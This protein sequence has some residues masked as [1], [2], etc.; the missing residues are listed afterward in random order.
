MKKNSKVYVLILS[1]WLVLASAVIYPFITESTKAP[2]L[3]L[4]ILLGLNGAFILY[5]WLNGTKDIVYTLNYWVR[6]NDFDKNKK[7]FQTP[8]LIY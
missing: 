8:K 1:T 5:F 4:S 2:N 6:K 3:F 7:L